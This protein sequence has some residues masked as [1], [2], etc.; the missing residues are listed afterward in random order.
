MAGFRLAVLTLVSAGAMLC[1]LWLLDPLVSGSGWLP[2]SAAV[3]TAMALVGA[4]LR[5]LPRG[6]ALLVP[7]AQLL[8]ALAVV[9]AVFAPQAAVAGFV[10]TPASLDEL[11]RI[12]LQGRQEIDANP[13]PV[14]GTAG[15]ALVFALG[16]AAAG[17]VGDVLSVTARTPALTGVPLFAMLLFPLAVDDQGVGAGAFALA[18]CGYLALLAVDGW[19]RGS[20][21]APH[22]GAPASRALGA[23]R[24]GLLSAGVAAAALA[25]ALLVPVALPN[26][27]SGSVYEMAGPPGPDQTVTTTHPLVSLR[28]D[29]GSRSD[30]VVLEYT[31]DSSSPAYLRTFVLDAFDGTDW[32]MSPVRLDEG[33]VL[34]GAS[35]PPVPGL[36]GGDYER[37]SSEI[38]LERDVRDTAFLPL[39]YP[40]RE[41]GIEGEWYADP[42]SLMV[43]GT[44]VQ[45]PSPR[46][47]VTSLEL[48]PD[49]AR[50][51]GSGADSLDERFLVVP[52]GV[53]DRVAR[54]ARSITEDADDRLAQ[55]VALQDWFTGDGGFRY[56]LN[57]PPLPQGADPL[58]HFLFD[59]RVGYCEQFAASMALM[60]RQ[61]DIPARVAVG[62]T[63]GSRTADGSWQV[64]ESDAHA[65]PELYFPGQGWLRFEPTPGDGQGTASV[66]EY[67][68]GAPSAPSDRESP[69]EDSPDP[70]ES[71]APE[72]EDDAAPDREDTAAPDRELPD[73]G[74]A[75]PGDGG[76]P[77]P[78]AAAAAVLV[79]LPALLR[80]VRRRARLVRAGAAA[81][82]AAAEAAWAEVRDLCLDL[83]LGWSTVESPRAAA[84]RIASAAAL[85]DGSAEALERIARAEETA[86]YA[87]EPAAQ[88]SLPADLRTLS[89]ALRR[90][91]APA[92]RARAALL[93]RSLLR[94]PARPSGPV[95]PG[96]PR[97]AA[98]VPGR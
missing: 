73:S 1:G 32:T 22:A 77:W 70:E 90:S 68:T 64:R 10:P 7:P 91:A 4:G 42:D 53:D 88:P 43:F 16:A 78:A 63:A 98:G 40:A 79:L 76:G 96:S 21:W 93:P 28:H 84:L 34:D 67:A 55:A 33:D 13:P 59:S 31:T 14:A 69:E 15:V 30:S 82:V 6:A 20:G 65:W 24:H 41:L 74:G 81:P 45:D 57:P 3:L 89:M 12:L 87:P 26:L 36:T 17:A 50:L 61:L 60:A 97:R 86:R 85:D 52:S 8:V 35:L 46:Y 27:A 19:V 29:L 58:A 38:T 39:P 25:L 51:T 83:G 56:D 75:A 37:V 47:T 94:L 11:G 18:A 92:A 9:T 5:F 80:A 48:Q 71:E 49:P 23:L 54:L 72:E 44:S 66:P 95:G 2:P 62:Y